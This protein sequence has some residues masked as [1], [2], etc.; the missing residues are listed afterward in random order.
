MSVY[1]VEISNNSPRKYSDDDVINIIKRAFEYTNVKIEVKHSG[2]IKE[3]DIDEPYNT[4]G[5]S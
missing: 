5:S 1:M 4:S 3:T 2:S